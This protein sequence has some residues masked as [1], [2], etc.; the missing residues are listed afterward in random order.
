M[1]AKEIKPAFDDK[2]RCKTESDAEESEKKKDENR[3]TNKRRN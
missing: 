1:G 3:R 2:N